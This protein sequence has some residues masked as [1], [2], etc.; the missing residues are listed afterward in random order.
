MGFRLFCEKYHRTSRLNGSTVEI[1]KN[2]AKTEIMSVIN[3]SE[4]L[5]AK[6]LYQ[7]STGDLFLQSDPEKEHQ[8]IADILGINHCDM[9][10]IY[11]DMRRKCMDYYNIAQMD[12][13]CNV[14]DD[15]WKHFEDDVLPKLKRMFPNFRIRRY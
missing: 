3:D 14:P 6:L 10:H 8:D 5:S 7:F 15:L 1:F 2:P 12:N 11:I 13:R 4:Y 9:M